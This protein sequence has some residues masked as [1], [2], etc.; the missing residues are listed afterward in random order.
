MKNNGQK[1]RHCL[2]CGKTIRSSRKIRICQECRN[3]GKIYSVAAVVGLLG[4]GTYANKN[5]KK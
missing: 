5:S 1:E 2:I 3:Q 4:L